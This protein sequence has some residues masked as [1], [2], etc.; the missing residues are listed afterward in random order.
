MQPPKPFIGAIGGSFLLL[1]LL[2]LAMMCYLYGTAFHDTSRIQHMKILYVDYDQG[3][4]GKSVLAAYSQLQNPGFPSVHQHSPGEFPSTNDVRKAVC[5]GHYWGAIYANSNASTR[6]SSALASHE[7]AESYDNT[8]ALTYV[9]NG[10]RYAAYAQTI[11]ASLEALVSATGGAYGQLNGTTAMAHVNV[12]DPSIAQTLL[13]PIAAS[14]IDIK[15]TNQ[16]P[17]FFYNTVS[18]V[19]PILM[20]FFFI[21]AVNGISAEF[22]AFTA[23]LSVT[24]HTLFRA[25]LSLLYTFLGA[26]AMA[27]YIWAFR[28]DWSTSDGNAFGRTWMALW[29]VMHVNYLWLDATTVVVPPKFMSFVMLT[30]IILNVSS[31]IGPFDLSPGF[32]RW[33][34][35]LPAYEL[36]HVL[37][38]IW[39]DG[40]NRPALH[41]SLPILF[42]WWIVGWALFVVGMRARV[43]ALRLMAGGPAGREEREEEGVVKM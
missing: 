24:R 27:G 21:M 25:C 12:S 15:P 23:T 2:F 34:N 17:R 22:A 30:W 8:A 43:R 36:Y 6:L 29:L 38:Y 41:Q 3:L 1:Q 33:G 40:C 16:G 26:L 20:Q 7:A 35:A 39:T 9:W 5:H 11:Y 28:E 4:I 18:M 32:Y 10:A 19:M 31:T 14:A 37:L 13:A 42:S